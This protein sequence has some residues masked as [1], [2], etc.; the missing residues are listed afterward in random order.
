MRKRRSAG[1]RVPHGVHDERHES[2]QLQLAKDGWVHTAGAEH[3]WNGVSQD[4]DCG[5][6]KSG[7]PLAVFHGAEDPG[8]VLGQVRPDV[9]PAVVRDDV[10]GE[11]DWSAMFGGGMTLLIE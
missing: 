10:E 4:E 3:R 5:F 1:S 2:R 9:L 8:R 6:D 11:G 7:I